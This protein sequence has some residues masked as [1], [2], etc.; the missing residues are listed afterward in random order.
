MEQTVVAGK[1]R[2]ASADRFAGDPRHERWK[3]LATNASVSVAATLAVAKLAAWLITDSVTILS[4]LLDSMVDVAASLVTLV[5]VRHALRPPDRQHRFGH[6]KAEPLGALVQAAFIAGSGVVVVFQAIS[7]LITPQPVTDTGIGIAVML[8]SIALTLGLVAF[9]GHV[10][11]RT[12]SMAIRADSLHYT[13]DMLIG[14]AVIGTLLADRHLGVAWLDPL[15]A[16]G[17]AG[18]LLVNAAAI[19]RR[20][21]DALMD[22]E[23]PAADRE[24][25][26]AIVLAHDRVEGLHDLR[27]RTSGT[28]TFIALHLEVDGD[29]TVSVA[30]DIA[31]AVED[32]LRSAFPG[33][34]VLVHQ[35]P[36]GLEDH[37]LDHIIRDSLRS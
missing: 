26:K 28:T 36:A 32:E 30:H 31:D 29:L 7:R 19:G 8:F 11:R 20:S 37:R 21:L 34:Q 33:A 17:I 16:L 12:G 15:V 27:T 22:R 1:P 6:G 2:D 14:L 24:R 13:G 10:V 4:S 3:R 9:Q 25:I 35:E 23:L 5:T 18:Y